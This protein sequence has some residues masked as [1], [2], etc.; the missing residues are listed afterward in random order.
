[1]MSNLRVWI[2]KS[3]KKGTVSAS[4]IL[5]EKTTTVLLISIR[6]LVLLS[7]D[8]GEWVEGFEFDS[9]V[10]GGELPVGAGALGVVMGCPGVDGRVHLVGASD[11]LAQALA[12]EDAQFDF[13]HVQP[14]AAL[15][16]V[17]NS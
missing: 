7:F 3:G 17:H 2:G 9:G 1:M 6:L 11:A 14:A 16:H 10:G 15:R 5:I 4:R 8:V 13:G 12:G